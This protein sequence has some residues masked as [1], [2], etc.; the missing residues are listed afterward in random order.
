MKK[1]LK[2]IFIPFVICHL[3]F[4]ICFAQPQQNV[5]PNGYNK[6]YYE[7]GKISSEGMMKDSR[8]EGYWKTYSPNGKI[9]SQGNRKNFE[10]DSLW[11]FYNENGKLLT[12]INYRNGKKDGMKRTWD[13]DGFILSE[14][15]Y[16]SD[17]KQGMTITYY[18]PDDTIQTKGKVKMK[19]PFDKGKENGTAFEY[20]KNGNIITILE[21]SYGVLKKQELVNRTDKSGQ[22]QGT[23]KEFF[24]SGKVKSETAYQNGKKTGYE[25][26]FTETGSLANVEKFI[27]DSAV[28]EA[29]ELTT[30]LEVRNEYYE[31]GAIKKTG[32]YLY[33]VAEGTHKEYSPEG[34]ITGAKIFHEGN[35]IGE[36]LIDE[37]G[38][39][40]GAWTEYHANGKIK[41]KGSY[42][43]G[44][45]TGEWVFYHPNG[46]T[47]QKGKY[48]KKGK[49]QGLWQWYYDSGNLLRE[50]TYLNGKREGALTEWSDA[51]KDSSGNKTE[52][53]VITKG[54]YIDGMKEGKWFYQIQDYREEGMY[55]SD[56][57]DGA[58]ESYYVDNNQV[59][60]AGKFVE[61]LPDGKHTYYYHDGKKEEEGKYIMGNKDGN[62]EYFN[63]DGTLLITITFHKDREIKFDGVKVKPLLPGETLK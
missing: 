6:F 40:Q 18:A 53:Q 32:T 30:K 11:K 48:D 19:I 36:G 60:F 9:K 27:G 42:E 8:P 23:W 44:I 31:D 51:K 1:F 50:E 43:N 29:P 54:E 63:P 38:N 52:A 22:K 26:K 37:A 21:Y 41:G 35:L 61:G 14:E 5:N 33:G 47:E 59:R 57:K 58:W 28:K 46:K 4:V 16:S 13:A 3:S 17:V 62:W 24:P 25:K 45:K 56:N 34:K 7:N 55:K 20:D 2:Y 15:N 39:Q 49:P 12:E 10:L